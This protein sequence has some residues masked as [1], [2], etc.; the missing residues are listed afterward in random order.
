MF[1]DI[2]MGPDTKYISFEILGTL[3]ERISSSVQPHR[4]LCR[5]ILIN[6]VCCTWS[7]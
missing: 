5:G 6:E 3:N 1:A 4:E 7:Y 2:H